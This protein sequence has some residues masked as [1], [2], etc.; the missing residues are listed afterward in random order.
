MGRTLEFVGGT[1]EGESEE[2]TGEEDAVA[3]TG[4]NSDRAR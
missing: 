1:R 2:V 3:G 4:E